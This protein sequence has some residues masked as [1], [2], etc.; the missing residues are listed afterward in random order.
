MNEQCL[1][2]ARAHARTDFSKKVENS[3]SRR[4]TIPLKCEISLA[5]ASPRVNG[6]HGLRKSLR[7]AQRV[8]NRKIDA[9]LG[10]GLRYVQANQ[11]HPQPRPSV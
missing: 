8:N 9:R 6:Y 3:V 7:G 11:L 10:R 5:N 1:A 4:V 2:Y